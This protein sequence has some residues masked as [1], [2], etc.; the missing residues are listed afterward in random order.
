[1]RPRLVGMS[2]GLPRLDVEAAALELAALGFDG[3]EVFVGQ[4]GPGIVDVPVLEAHAR[5][6][7]EAV[8][9]A[10]LT[11][12]TLNTAGSRD[13]D[14]SDDAAASTEALARS[15]RLAAA[16]G[17]ER[18]LVWDGRSDAPDA[19]A[20]LASC[21]ARAVEASG[22]S[23][24]PRVSVEL[25]PFTFALARG[26]LEE[27][28]AALLQVGA[29]LCLDFCHFGVALGPSFADA[30]TPPVLDAVDHVH[31]CDTDCRTSELHFPPGEGVLDLDALDARLEGRDLSVAWDLFGWAAPRLA[32]RTGLPRFRAAVE[33]LV[34]APA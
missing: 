14:P 29:S 11:V 7:A 2:I 8:R 24:P 6:V 13:F 32:L 23:G 28:A 17:A 16:M 20:Q 30:L 34:G 33:R 26:L 18:V 9:A 27:T 1:M 15:L 10:G 21:I 12:T 3:M 4:M 25:H 31:W 22:L 19:P 5:S